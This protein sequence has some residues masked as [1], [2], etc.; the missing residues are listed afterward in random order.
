MR[1]SRVL[2]DDHLP[3]V[4][5]V[6]ARYRGAGLPYDDLVQEGSIGLLEAIERY[7]ERCGVPFESYA[8]FR[9]HRAIRNA[10]TARAR[11]IRLPKHVVERRRLID[12]EN[13]RLF[14]ATGRAP[15]VAELAAETGLRPDAIRAAVDAAAD[16]ISLDEP[17][18]PDGSPRIGPRSSPAPACGFDAPTI[19]GFPDA[20]R[21]A[22]GDGIQVEGG[23]R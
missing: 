1:S 5:K 22:R 7:D 10:L 18:T 13:A 23:V 4:R 14:A 19:R 3:L 17:V 21:A 6:A 20:L 11:L 12:R 2:P 8:R 9:I 15:T 16:A